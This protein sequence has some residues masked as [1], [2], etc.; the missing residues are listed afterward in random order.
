[1]RS[2]F[3]LSFDVGG[4]VCSSPGVSGQVPLSCPVDLDSL[5]MLPRK[6]GKVEKIGPYIEV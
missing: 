3:F 5:Y 2:Q 4:D 1:M 6:R